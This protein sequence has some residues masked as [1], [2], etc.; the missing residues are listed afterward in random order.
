MYVG[1]KTLVSSRYSTVTTD[2][3]LK[4]DTLEACLQ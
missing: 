3:L 2:L 4:R 1:L